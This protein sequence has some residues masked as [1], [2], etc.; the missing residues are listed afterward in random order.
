M[1]ALIAGAKFRGEFEDRL[2]AVLKEVTDSS[3][4]IILFIDEI[5]TVVGAGASEGAMD[6]GN[7]L[8][9]MLGRGELRC[10]GATTLDEYRKYIEK[11]PALERRF[12]QVY[13]D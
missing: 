11:D 8:K 5:H 4:G 13:V 9:P 6:A 12:Q 2:K 1:G 7:L 10:I 3:G